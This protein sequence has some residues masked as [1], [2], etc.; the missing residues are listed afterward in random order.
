MTRNGNPDPAGATAAGVA[1][2][3]EFL[4]ERLKGFGPSVG[5]VL[6]SGL[7][8]LAGRV[9]R[10]TVVAYGDIP[11]F[12]AAGVAGH[13][14]ELVLGELAGTRVLVQD[15][16]SHLY[17]GPAPEA[18]VLPVR[19]LHALGVGSLLVT[20]AAGALRPGFRPPALMLIADH[21][22]LLFWSPLAGPVV[23]PEPRFPDVSRV[24]DPGLRA[25]ARAV[26][27]A[28]GIA[29][30][31][32][33]YVG[34]LGPSY[35]TPAEVQMLRRFGDAIGM[36]TVPVGVTAAALGVRVLGIST[37]ANAP[38]GTTREGISHEDVLRA[39]R[40]VASDLERLIRG[41]LHRLARGAGSGKGEP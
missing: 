19:V 22:N 34:V 36:S 26:A 6:G 29:L 30:E 39:G 15:G 5:I 21:V 41:V 20:N 24:Y 2:A 31:E 9:E 13:R 7:G 8:G 14:G 27:M 25:V 3:A 4:R 33:V 32:G 18:V 38:A 23:P 11:G 16:R 28:E 35:E 1:A 12:P 17:E 10:A 40:A 37:I